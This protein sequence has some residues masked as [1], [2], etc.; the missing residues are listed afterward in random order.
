[1]RSAA[2]ELGADGRIT[3]WLSTQVPHRDHFGISMTLGLD[4]AQL[5]VIAPDVGGGFGAKSAFGA[6]EAIV[7]WLARH[8]GKPVRWTETRS[9]S[10]IAL[11]HGRGQRLELALGGKSDGTILAYRMDILQ[12]AARTRGSPPSCPI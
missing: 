5:R 7:V 2:A 1:M 8:L 10:M 11:P 9:E 12:D 3:A 6:E 4:P